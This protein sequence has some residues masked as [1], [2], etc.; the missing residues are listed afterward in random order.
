AQGR[1]GAEIVFPNLA[2]RKGE[3]RV[4]VYL[5]CENA[6]HF[7]DQVTTAAVLHLEDPNPEPGLVVLPH[8]WTSPAP[9]PAR[10]VTVHGLPL[11]VDAADSL[12]L[13]ASGGIFEPEETALIRHVVKPGQRVLDIGAN[14]GY[15]TVLLAQLVGQTGQVT[16]VEPD[17]DNF[18][19]LR[20]NRAA[21]AH[22]DRVRLHRA[23]LGR[24]AG[25]ADLHR[26]PGS[27]G[28]HRLYA[29]VCCG[30]E[31]T[32]VPVLRGDDLNLAPLDF[33]K[34]DIEGYEPAAL[35]GLDHT[36]AASPDLTI[37]CEFSPLS[38]WEAGFVPR[39]F[40][41]GMARR[42]FAILGS[43]HGQWRP[44]DLSAMLDALDRLPGSDIRDLLAGLRG[45]ADQAQDIASAASAFLT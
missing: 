1:G 36:L 29:S 5:A 33:L 45:M 41:Q 44:L 11:A 38:L 37:L 15:H 24:E 6:L 17:P 27:G 22:P 39:D 12:G 4:S 32:S 25:R 28:M 2:L 16:A 35:D 20:R 13:A 10:M 8:A 40:L 9:D 31:T 3:Y 14:I 21:L 42:G 23:A 7:Y 26:A 43:D 19:L 30:P 18:R 34:I